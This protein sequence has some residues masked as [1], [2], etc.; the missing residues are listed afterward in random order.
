MKGSETEYPGGFLSESCCHLFLYESLVFALFSLY[1]AFLLVLSGSKIMPDSGPLLFLMHL[2]PVFELIP[3]SVL[4]M[5][6]PPM[7][8]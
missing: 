8:V 1:Q 5:D 7:S 3:E 2:K 6:L 4:Q